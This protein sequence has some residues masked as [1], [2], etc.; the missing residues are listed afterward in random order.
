MANLLR[1]GL[2]FF[3]EV[4][5][6]RL[7]GL[8]R[9]SAESRISARTESRTRRRAI[10]RT[11]SRIAFVAYFVLLTALLLTQDPVLIVG[12]PPTVLESV[13]HLLSFTVLS[14]LAMAASWARSVWLTGL[15][16]VSY[17]TATELL[18]GLVS[19]RT[20]EWGDWFQDVAGVA[21][22]IGV[23]WWA[24]RAVDRLGRSSS[25]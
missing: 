2:P 11:C 19:R 5:R 21:I 7:V 6:R 23:Y 15:G 16:L 14:V 17:A 24:T 18:Q 10:F 12:A 4:T 20:P 9:D 22:G 25:S 3:M 8:M 1:V 13:A